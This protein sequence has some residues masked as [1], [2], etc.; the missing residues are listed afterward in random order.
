MSGKG[1]AF[2]TR[3]LI[4]SQVEN[5]ELTNRRVTFSARVNKLVPKHLKTF[6]DLRRIFERLVKKMVHSIEEDEKLLLNR[7]YSQTRV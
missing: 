3:F 2:I 7:V 5:L 4:F 1:V 6:S